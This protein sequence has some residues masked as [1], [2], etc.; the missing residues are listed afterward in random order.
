VKPSA[1]LLLLVIASLMLLSCPLLAD[2]QPDK[3]KSKYAD[4]VWMQEDQFNFNVG[5]YVLSDIDTIIKK[6]GAAGAGS[7]ISVEDDLGLDD[8]NNLFRVDGHFRIK[9]RHR[10]NFSVYDLSRDDSAVIREDLDFGDAEFLAG[11]EVETDLGLRVFKFLYTWSA[12]QNEKWD[13][14]LSGGAYILELDGRLAQ[15]DSLLAERENATA[16]FPVI[17]FRASY[18]FAGKWMFRT[19]V[20]YFEIDGSDVE[21]QLTDVLIAVEHNTF[22]A[23][24]FGVAYNKVDLDAKDLED[25][26]RLSLDYEGLL[27][28]LKLYF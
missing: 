19:H 24:G 7:E 12:F 26:D 15:P 22:K 18:R 2:D 16:G 11:L 27:V 23:V 25:G 20:D 28:Y 21:G 5:F 4:N 6:S 9:P 17:G 3:Q 8:D 14:G 1:F 10:I 13:L